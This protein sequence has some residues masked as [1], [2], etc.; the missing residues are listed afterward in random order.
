M[1]LTR[2]RNLEKSNAKGQIL[3]CNVIKKRNFCYIHVYQDLLY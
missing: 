3:S 1:V 2:F